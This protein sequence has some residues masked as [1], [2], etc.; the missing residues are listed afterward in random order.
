KSSAVSGIRSAPGT[1][2]ASAIRFGSERAPSKPPPAKPRRRLVTCSTSLPRSRETASS[3]CARTSE[4]TRIATSFSS[5]TV[6]GGSDGNFSVGRSAALRARR[7]CGACR[8]HASGTRRAK[9][10]SPH[11]TVTPAAAPAS[12]SLRVSLTSDGGLDQHER[13]QLALQ[14]RH[15]VAIGQRGRDVLGQRVEAAAEVPEEQYVPLVGVLVDGVHGGVDSVQEHVPVRVAEAG[16][17]PLR[18]AAAGAQRDRGAAGIAPQVD[19]QLAARE[20]G[21]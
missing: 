9:Y 1:P 8:A 15:D 4:R 7:S 16:D 11:A 19:V 12:T 6:S 10:G 20:P 2:A 14:V 21:P 13:P 5:R 18:L 17:Q 3:T